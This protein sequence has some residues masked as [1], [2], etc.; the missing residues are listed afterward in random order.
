M[1][2]TT[3]TFWLP[4]QASTFAQMVDSA[5]NLYYWISVFF[6]VLITALIV[7]FIA[8]YMRKRPDQM[9]ESQ[10]TH[11]TFL[12]TLWTAVPLVLVMWFFVIGM[13]GYL[14]MRIPPGNAMVVNVTGQKWSWSYRYPQG[15]VTDTLVVPVN[16]PVK[17]VMTST[18]VIHS[19]YI[20]AFRQKADVVPNR[21]HSLWFQATK[22]GIYPVQCTQY[23]GTNHSYMWSSV[24]VVDAPTYAAWLEGA[25]DPSK[26]KT[27]IEYG[28]E[29]WTKRGCNACHS[30][31]GSKLVGPSWK[32]LY[33]RTEHFTDGSS[34]AADENYLRESMLNPAAKVVAGY[35]PVMPTY[36]GILGDKEVE[37][38]IAYI[39]S[40]K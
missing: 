7:I 1:E 27:A 2:T 33:N 3:K 5:F 16:Q 15:F 23:C 35:Q 17:L 28:Q 21:Y 32:G 10:M 40:L 34:A 22:P 8:K 39:Q 36:K 31:D 12:E 11:N 14:K 26:G 18:D 9:A 13:Q 29:L 30:V 20:A 4:E 38:I 24:K 25:S 37:S 19:F 6:F